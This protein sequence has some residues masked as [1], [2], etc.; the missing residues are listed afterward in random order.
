MKDL[1]L[2]KIAETRLNEKEMWNIKGGAGHV[3]TD[4]DGCGTSTNTGS[5]YGTDMDAEEVDQDNL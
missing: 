2:N 3:C 5:K 4:S 1:K